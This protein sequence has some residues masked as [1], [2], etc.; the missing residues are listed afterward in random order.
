MHYTFDLISFLIFTASIFVLIVQKGH[1]S[2][3]YRALYPM[4]FITGIYLIG[5][6]YYAF[7]WH[8]KTGKTILESFYEFDLL[9]FRPSTNGFY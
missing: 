9:Y 7:S 1:F 8:E 2:K 3:G 4:V 6:V 5:A